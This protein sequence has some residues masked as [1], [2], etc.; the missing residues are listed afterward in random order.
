M[1][2]LKTLLLTSAVLLPLSLGGCDRY[3]STPFD[4]PPSQGVQMASYEAADKLAGQS[5]NVV[6]RET[7]IAVGTLSDIN[8]IESSSAL[9]RMIAEQVGA[10]FVQL[11]YTVSE[12]KLRADINVQQPNDGTAGA[13]EY[14]TSRNREQLAAHTNARAVISGTYAVAGENILVNLRLIDVNTARILAAHDYSMPMNED[15]RRL[16]DSDTSTGS[17]IFSS[18]WAK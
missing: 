3:T 11:G 8:D 10:R 17:G 12:I 5:L 4:S 15:T 16:L 9:G 14:M 13:G 18:G 1:I 2:R 6:T 7:P